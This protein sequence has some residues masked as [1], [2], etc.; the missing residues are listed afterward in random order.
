METKRIYVK[1]CGITRLEDALAALEAGADALGFVAYER[2]P[3]H[4]SPS[5]VAALVGRLG[6]GRADLVGVFVNPSLELVKAYLDAGLTVAQLHGDESPSF[7]AAVGALAPVWR[8]VRLKDAAAVEDAAGYPAARFV[9]DAFD[10]SAR[11]GTG[12]TCDWGLARRAVTTL[13]APVLLAGGLNRGNLLAALEAAR[14]FGVDL[15]S[16]VESSPGVKDH[17]A[18]RE[19]MALVRGTGVER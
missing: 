4:I 9:L 8:A 6:A 7:A 15:S 14:P 3:R 5:V 16:G 12:K 18:I 13:P 11:G 1:I 19:L 10:P 17:S 2:S